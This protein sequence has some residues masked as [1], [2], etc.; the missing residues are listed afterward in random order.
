MLHCAFLVTK[1][2]FLGKKVGFFQ[3][4]A[5]ARRR[6]LND[7]RARFVREIQSGA[8]IVRS[9]FCRFA[10]AWGFMKPQRKDTGVKT[11]W[12]ACDARE[13]R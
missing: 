7:K 9:P 4:K 1:A 11:A 3:R 2:L 5:I 13:E 8:A 10:P 6:K 12:F